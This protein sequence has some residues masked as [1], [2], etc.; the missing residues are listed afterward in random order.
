MPHLMPI[1]RLFFALALLG[2]GIEHFVF[3]EFVTG[4]APP[5]PASLPGK[6]I[7]VYGSGAAIAGAG[8][9][10]LAGKKGR[11]LVMLAGMLILLWALLRHIPVV[12][13]DSFF[14]GSWTRAGKALMLFGGAFAVAGTLPA[15]R[16]GR[17]LS[18]EYIVLGRICLGI[19]LA[20]SGV[21][22]FMFT[23]F[24]VTLIPEWFPGNATWWARFA[25]VALLSGGIGLLLPRTAAP[26]ALLSGLMV[27]SW[28][29]IVHVPRAFVSMSDS[30]AVFEALAVSGI[31]F[32]IAGFLL[33]RRT[34]TR[35]PARDQPLAGVEGRETVTGILWGT[36]SVHGISMNTTSSAALL[37]EPL[38]ISLTVK[39]LDKS[40]A[41]YTGML[42]F[43]IAKTYD[44]GGKIGGY[45][46]QA[47]DARIGIGQDDGAK[48]WDRVKGQGCSIQITTDQRVDD[49]ADRIKAAGGTLLSEPADMRWGVRMF[50]VLDPDGF[51]LGVSQPLNT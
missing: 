18:G 43:T 12:A 17:N 47:G 19:F 50:Q 15:E 45:A 36:P 33:A 9:A 51:K 37:A 4:R 25:G 22:H 35:L 26:A 34:G 5:W 38:S 41:W 14:A 10:I 8:L 1:G 23:E 21:Q 27:F 40:L 44:H 46:L 7:W 30:I 16:G 29:W 48:G 31:A 28:V 13:A 49:F 39:D 20:I 6:T 32:V 42:G 24:V 11:S 3:Q 2:L